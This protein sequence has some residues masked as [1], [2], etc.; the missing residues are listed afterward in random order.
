MSN[1]K[2]KTFLSFFFN[3]FFFLFL[4]NLVWVEIMF[5]KA[6]HAGAT[7][8]TDAVTFEQKC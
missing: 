8:K 6:I 7:E 5:I 2:K 4:I 3:F 1:V